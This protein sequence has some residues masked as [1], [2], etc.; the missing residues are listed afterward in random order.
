MVG[1]RDGTSDGA[2][3]TTESIRQ[4]AAR[5]A[6][7]AKEQAGRVSQEAQRQGRRLIDEA[8]SRLRDEA[9]GQASRAAGSMRDIS[10][11][12]RSM[13]EASDEP[14]GTVPRLMRDGADQL[15]SFAES[16]DAEGWGAARSRVESLARRRP[17]MFL[18][19]AFGAGMLAGRLFRNTDTDQVRR[20]MSDDT[21]TSPTGRRPGM[22][23]STPGSTSPATVRESLTAGSPDAVTAPV[24]SRREGSS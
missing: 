11:E 8:G 20:H 23:A 17:A 21:E 1:Q 13:A 7:T 15:E 3:S 2:G 19:S 4:E 18:A 6:D 14:D 5:T 22:E 10:A 24:E 16:L 9:D 12:I